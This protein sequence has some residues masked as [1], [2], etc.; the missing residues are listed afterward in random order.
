LE[1]SIASPTNMRKPYRCVSFPGIK[2]GFSTETDLGERSDFALAIIWWDI[3]D[4]DSLLTREAQVDHLRH[5]FVRA[6]ARLE[7]EVCRPVVSCY[8]NIATVS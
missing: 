4:C 5:T 2:N 6:V 3:I 8:V 1:R 7:V